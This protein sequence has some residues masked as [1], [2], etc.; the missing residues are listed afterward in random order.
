MKFLHDEVT[1]DILFI[2][3]NIKFSCIIFSIGIYLSNLGIQTTFFDFALNQKKYFMLAIPKLKFDSFYYLGFHPSLLIHSHTKAEAKV[4]NITSNFAHILNNLKFSY[5]YV[6]QQ[7][8]LPSLFYPYNPH[9]CERD[10]SIVMPKI[11]HVL[12]VIAID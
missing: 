9:K 4:L 12:G 3:I 10:D 5:S 2:N 7:T 11:Y 1:V 8:S 6:C